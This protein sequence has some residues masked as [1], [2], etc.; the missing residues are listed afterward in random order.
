MKIKN[1]VIF[2][3]PYFGTLPN[4]FSFWLKS[5]EYNENIS[6]LLFTDDETVLNYFVP[7]NV[8]IEIVSFNNF[9]SLI[10]KK[11]DFKINIEDAYKLTDFKPAYGE[12]FQDYI[13]QYDFWGFTDIDLIYGDFDKFINNEILKSFDKIFVHGHLSIIKNKDS[14]NSIYKKDNY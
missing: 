11:Y 10:Q 2:I 1:S 6:W 4:Y 12:I 7:G 9:K 5:C 14:F 3:V 13:I 8:R